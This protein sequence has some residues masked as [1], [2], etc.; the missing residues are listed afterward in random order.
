M[1][2]ATIENELK[3]YVRRGE[4]SAIR[5]ASA[6]PEAY[7]SYTAMQRMALTEAEAN[8]YLGD[9]LFHIN[10]EADAER[11]F[12]QAIALD[13][14]LLQAQAALG[15][16][17]VYQ[18]KYAEAKKYL[19]KATQSPQTYLIHYL[20][21]FVLSREGLSPGGRITNYSRET[22]VAMREQLLK[23]IKLAPAYAPSHYLLAL[24]D[25]V[26]EEHLD[27]AL[28]M[29]QKARQLAP[30]K[31]SYALLLAQIHLRRSETADARNILESLTRNS[32]TAVRSEA[33]TLLDSLSQTNTN[34]G[35][36]RNTTTSHQVS[37]SMIAEPTEAGSAP[38]MIGGSSG[39]TA[40]RDGNTIESSGSLPSVDDLLAHY[41]EA[42]GGAAAINK[43]TSRVIT[44]T[45]DVAGVSRGGS[46]ETYAQ[47]PNKMVIAMDAH[48]FGKLK[49][50]FNGK[51]GWMFAQAAVHPVTGVD[52]AI[53]QRDA[54]FYST[55]RTRKNFAKV[56]LA[57]TSKIGYRDVYVVDMQPAIGPLERL[58]LDSQTFLPVRI[59]T[60][61]TVGRAA[62]PVEIYLDDWKEVDGVKYPFSISQSSPSVKLAFT[63][64]EIRHNVTIDVKMFEPRS[65]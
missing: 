38:R 10:R 25:L 22:A 34:A 20:Y 28:E 61:R 8:Y 46:F 19:Q 65:K 33:Q 16:I 47:A 40:I 9:L 45:L 6:D 14:N 59:N 3:A 43:V 30:G 50:G 35:A 23:S 36:N 55:L 18:R 49:M 51:N 32:D 17:Y 2:L 58:Y 48:P 31:A 63:V 26:T 29:A 24:V 1:T 60:V 44:G 62:E 37:S 11:Y 15:L 52:L 42:A 27:E 12:K 54:D 41:V 21:A 4:F 53:L 5:I 57:G 56:T 39:G 64:K 7:A 13:P